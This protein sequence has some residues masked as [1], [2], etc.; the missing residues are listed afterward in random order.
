M[1]EQ[2]RVRQPSRPKRSIST[3]PHAAQSRKY[4]LPKS[5]D[6]ST[7][8][9]QSP[10]H[11]VSH[12]SHPPVAE[13]PT[14]FKLVLPSRLGAEKL[15]RHTLAW[16]L[17]RLGFDASRT[18]DIQTA[19]SEACINAIEH[20]NQESADLQV[21]VILSVTPECL[22]VVVSDDGAFDYR[23]SDCPPAT[24]EQKVAGLAPARGMGLM[25]MRA[26]VDE[27]GFL[28][29]TA[30]QGNCCRLRVYRGHA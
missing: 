26:L 24:I 23:A 14:I 25:L 7:L 2:S 5:A 17:P 4:P 29:D 8:E 1:R 27:V 13:P 6:R 18:A 9:A 16:L 28:P 11:T 10:P 19:A 30:G 21:N 12:T 3:A 15:V 20:G 22:D